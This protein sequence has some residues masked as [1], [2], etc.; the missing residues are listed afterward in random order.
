MGTTSHAAV[1]L[2][3]REARAMA[4]LAR[5]SNTEIEDL[6]DEEFQDLVARRGRRVA[7]L[8]QLVTSTFV[9]GRHFGTVPGVE[10]PFCFEPGADEIC[11]H[12]GWSVRLMAPPTSDFDG[13]VLSVTAEVGVHDLSGRLLI[14]VPRT[15]STRERRFRKKNK[16]W[17]FE[18]PRECA[19]ECQAMAF[20]RGKVAGVLSAAGLKDHFANPDQTAEDDDKLSGA[21]HGTPWTDADKSRLYALAPKAGLA[22]KDAWEAFVLATLGRGWI[23]T[24]DDVEELARALEVLRAGPV[25]QGVAP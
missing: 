7:R 21:G 9:E 18:D 8:K 25:A 17:K 15:C 1:M 20:K 11:L 16:T 4:A 5:G 2:R 6:S 14:V 24:G 13:E 3:E 23:D 10:K 12:T 22:T 19:N